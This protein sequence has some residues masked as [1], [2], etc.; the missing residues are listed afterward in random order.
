MPPRSSALPIERHL[1]QSYEFTSHTPHIVA[2]T[3]AWSMASKPPEDESAS[4]EYIRDHFPRNGPS[5]SICA[6]FPSCR[7]NY[8][9]V[10]CYTSESP[11]SSLT[12]SV[13]FEKN[14]TS[15]PSPFAQHGACQNANLK[16]VT[17][18]TRHVYAHGHVS[19]AL[20]S[21]FA[22][23]PKPFVAVT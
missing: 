8:S 5:S 21:P 3:L 23:N 7:S 17:V 22:T 16:A 2:V 14:V 6:K 20:S 9:H 18:P 13:F 1:L 4:V 15:S 12:S 10:S 11:I 19:S